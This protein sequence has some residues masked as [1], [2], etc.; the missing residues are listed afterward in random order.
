MKTFYHFSDAIAY[1]R[2]YKGPGGLILQYQ[3]FQ[4]MNYVVTRSRDAES[5]VRV[6][7]TNIQSQYTRYGADVQFTLLECIPTKLGHIA[8]GD[9]VWE[10]KCNID[11]WVESR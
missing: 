3:P 1:I 5:I 11:M 10:L 9:I 2:G 4:K 6:P 8:Y 7:H